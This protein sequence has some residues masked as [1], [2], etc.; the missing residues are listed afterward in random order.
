MKMKHKKPLRE[1][2]LL[3]FARTTVIKNQL[4]IKASINVIPVI[5]NGVTSVEVNKYTYHKVRSDAQ[6]KQVHM[7]VITANSHARG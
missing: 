3:S 2:L 5:I 4:S 1:D 7:I 6:Q